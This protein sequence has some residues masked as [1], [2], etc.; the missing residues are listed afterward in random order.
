MPAERRIAVVTGS[1]AD[2]GLLQPVAALLKSEPGT[3]L[4]V[5]VT[6]SH[7]AP[8]FGS[9]VDE[10]EAD[11]FAVASRVAMLEP[12]DTPRDSARSTG[13]GVAACADAFAALRPHL[14]LLLGDRFEIFAAAAAAAIMRIP[15]AHLCGGDVTEGAVDDSLRH[16]ITKLA[17][18]HFPT[19]EPAAHRI[20]AMGEP[21]ARIHAVGST[22]LD[23]IRAVADPGR[24]ATFAALGIAPR[25]R[26]LLVTF[27]PET[28]RPGRALAQLDELLAAVDALGADYAFIVTKAN[29]DAEGRAINARLDS[30][31]AGRADV[32]LRASLGGALYVNAM[33]HADAVVGNSSSGLYEAPF[34][35]RPSVNL[36]ERQA[37]RPRAASVVDAPVARAAIIAAI[38]RA[39]ALDASAVASPY[40]DGRSAPR[41]VAVLRGIAEFAALLDKPS[42]RE[43][44][45]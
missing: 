44:A 19:N 43:A 17:H 23:R 38:A 40:G 39:L 4:Q 11:G 6:G 27:H 25:A 12:G 5:V 7:L 29:A 3:V 30:W 15:I 10:I 14:V 2:W 28:A 16:A 21:R 31:A 22:G 45:A 42:F 1:R 34:L 24:T 36:G 9:S 26:N 33:R 41:V 20:A 8:E 37:G 35:Q 18:L 13:R 32:A